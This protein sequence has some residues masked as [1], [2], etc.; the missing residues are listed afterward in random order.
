MNK[1]KKNRLSFGSVNIRFQMV[2]LINIINTKISDFTN[3][4]EYWMF[5]YES[6]SFKSDIEQ[7]WAD[8]LP[9]YELLHSYVRKKLR[10]FYGPDKISKNA[11]LPEHI[12]GNMN[13]QSWS[14]IIDIIIPYPG[15]NFLDVTPAM[16]NQ[17]YSPLVMFQIAEDFFVSMNMSR[18]PQDFWLNS[19][20]EETV[21]RPVLCQ[22]SGWDF[23][24]AKDFR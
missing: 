16:Q 24:N 6:V 19:V 3:A 11:P 17:G 10:D 18:L 1:N 7:V 5:P 4:A 8:I 22:P 9:L 21:D 23:C 15:R 20:L 12:L 2:S 14:K 13:A